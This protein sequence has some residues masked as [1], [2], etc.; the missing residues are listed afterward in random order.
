M[1]ALAKLNDAPAKPNG[2]MPDPTNE[3]D[4]RATT[5]P[6]VEGLV[7]GVADD[8][9]GCQ[10]MPTIDAVICEKGSDLVEGDCGSWLFYLKMMLLF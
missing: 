2:C 3:P 8:D 4:E 10:A 6:K 1:P 5:E 7:N 9:E